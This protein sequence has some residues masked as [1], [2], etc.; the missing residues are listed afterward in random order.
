MEK[1]KS[2][3]HRI[4]DPIILLQTYKNL[5]YLLLSIPL[6]FLYSMVISIGF[7]SGISLSI[8]FL[9]VVI[10]GILLFIIR[11]ITMFER[12]LTKSLLDIEIDNPPDIE[13]KNDI[14][15]T[16]KAYTSD[17]STWRGLGFIT[18]KF[19][20]GIAGFLLIW[21]FI[22]GVSMISSLINSPNNI[23]F[24]RLNGEPV[25]WNINSIP[26]TI[27]AVIIGICLILF[28]LHLTNFFG[29]IASKMGKALLDGSKT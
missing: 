25:V 27:F 1:N 20:F 15:E 18:L 11:F 10:L 8:I 3:I 28:L 29:Y 12:W 21:G 22:T 17:S 4:L 2:W 19:W 24:G 26:E 9:G 23:Q 14:K 16:L 5:F 13:S 6:G 7:I